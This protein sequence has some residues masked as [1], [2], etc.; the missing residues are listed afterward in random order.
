MENLSSNPIG[1]EVKVAQ[2]QLRKRWFLVSLLIATWLP[3]IFF[4]FL[5]PARDGVSSL[6]GI[7][8]VFLFLGTAHVPATLFFYLDGKFS[9]IIKK[10]PVRYIYAPL[11]LIVV[12]GL[13]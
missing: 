4:V 8:T 6:A 3:I 12:T 1:L 13:I 9:G 11:L 5:V 10:H 7:K 2:N